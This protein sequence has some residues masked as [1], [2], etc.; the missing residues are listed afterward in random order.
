LAEDWFSKLRGAPIGTIAL[1]ALAGVLYCELLTTSAEPLGGGEEA[2]SQA[3]GALLLT[4]WLWLVLAFL[5]VVGAVKGHMP[6]W[7]ALSALLLHPLS[8]VAA[9]AAVDAASR[10]IAGALLIVA[11][12]PLIIAGYA[13]WA[14]LPRLRALFPEFAT[15]ATAGAA[16]LALSVAALMT[17]I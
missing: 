15:S 17:G 4:L 9:F 2:F 10:H 14:R 7:A 1:L 13:L 6:R 5:L 3:Y 12:L 11:L 8:G 16:I